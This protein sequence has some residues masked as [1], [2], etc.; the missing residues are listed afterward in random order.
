MYYNVKA[1]TTIVDEAKGRE[2][3]V[4]LQYLVYAEDAHQAVK[5]TEDYLKDSVYPAE[6][7]GVT[8]TKV[9]DVLK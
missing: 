7:V 8:E 1:K 9:E 6:I 5:K 4:N 2:R 3:K